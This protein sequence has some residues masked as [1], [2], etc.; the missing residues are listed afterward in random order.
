MTK[1]TA[2]LLLSFL[3]YNSHSQSPGSINALDVDLQYNEK[4]NDARRHQK[5]M[6]EAY[7]KRYQNFKNEYNTALQINAASE[8]PKENP[9]DGTYSAILTNGGSLM[10]KILAECQSGK[11]ISINLRGKTISVQSTYIE[12]FRALIKDGARSGEVIFTD[13]FK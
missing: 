4:T 3:W 12:D 6:E 1:L 10:E 5:M 13:I 11:I 8:T 7:V 9:I 2:L